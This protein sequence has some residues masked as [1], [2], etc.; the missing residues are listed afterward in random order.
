MLMTPKEVLTEDQK[1]A[2]MAAVAEASMLGPETGDGRGWMFH[3]T[4]QLSSTHIL[5]GG[6]RNHYDPTE[7]PE[8]TFA[9][10]GCIAAAASFAEKRMDA[11]SPPALLAVLTSDLIAAGISI[12][13]NYANHGDELPSDWRDHVRDGGTVR[14]KGGATLPSLRRFDISGIPLHPDAAEARRDRVSGP[15]RYYGR[16]RPHPDEASHIAIIEEEAPCPT[17]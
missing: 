8:R 5:L 12:D 15:W 17:P 9:Y 16:C 6:F 1:A 2:W 13:P 4:D 14:I 10:F 11:D 7:A 3:G